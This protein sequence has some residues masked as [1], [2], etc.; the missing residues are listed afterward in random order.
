[1]QRDARTELGHPPQRISD[2][3]MWSWVAAFIGTALAYAAV[4]AMPGFVVMAVWVV[5]ALVVGLWIGRERATWW[6]V[7]AQL[8][9]DILERELADEQR[10]RENSAAHARR[11]A[12]R[13]ALERRQLGAMLAELR[14]ATGVTV[15]TPAVTPRNGRENAPQIAP[16]SAEGETDG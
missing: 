1:M 16:S 2:R 12:E 15:G 3:V 11:Q 14:D 8:A 7:Q 4:D 9:V 5:A 6:V 13:E 10:A